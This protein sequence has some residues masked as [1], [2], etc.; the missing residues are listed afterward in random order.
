[1]SSAARSRLLTGALLAGGALLIMG[2]DDCNQETVNQTFYLQD[3]TAF[4]GPKNEDNRPIYYTVD[5]SIDRFASGPQKVICDWQQHPNIPQLFE[6]YAPGTG[7]RPGIDGPDPSTDPTHV[8]LCTQPTTFAGILEDYGPH[9]NAVHDPDWRP[10]TPQAYSVHDIG[11]C[12]AF[13]PVQ[14]FVGTIREQFQRQADNRLGQQTSPE[15]MDIALWLDFTVELKDHAQDVLAWTDFT[16]HNIGFEER[17]PPASQSAA[18]LNEVV[19]EAMYRVDGDMQ[20]NFDPGWLGNSAGATFLSAAIQGTLFAS[21]GTLFPWLFLIGNCEK[22]RDLRMHLRG[23]FRASPDGGVGLVLNTSET[24]GPDQRQP[25]T[26]T[27]VQSWSI[28]RPVCNNRVKPDLEQRFTQGAIIGLQDEN[29]EPRNLTMRSDG[30]S[31][32]PWQW[33]I[34]R[35]EMTPTDI[36]LIFLEECDDDPE[37]CDELRAARV[38]GFDRPISNDYHVQ[39]IGGIQ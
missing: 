22:D 23:R 29:G 17:F 15:S 14:N 30:T 19:L 21:A 38:C 35:V 36:H 1:M 31:L 11:E 39:T 3:G 10:W 18:G 26:W 20:W 27:R 7:T 2:A 6:T 37:L 28:F 9:V 24:C 16:A 12:S 32:L 34:I 4:Q 8:F 13:L 5:S 33:P 25:C